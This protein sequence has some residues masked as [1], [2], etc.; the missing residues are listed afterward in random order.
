MDVMTKL[1]NMDTILGD[2]DN[3]ILLEYLLGAFRNDGRISTT[4]TFQIGTVV[5]YHANS[6]KSQFMG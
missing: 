5:D 6:T 1:A 2:H 3:T 4:N